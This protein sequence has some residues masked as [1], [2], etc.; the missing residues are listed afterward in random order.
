MRI[1]QKICQF[2]EARVKN[3]GTQHYMFTIFAMLNYVAP[4][5][6]SDL[7]ISLDENLVTLRVTAVLLCF[8]LCFVDYWPIRWRLHYFPLYW[9]CTLL[10]CLPF[11]GTYTALV[12]DEQEYWVFNALLS[13]LL[14]LMLVDWLSFVILATAGIITSYTAYVLCNHSAPIYVPVHDVYLF[15]YFSAFVLIA[16]IIFMRRKEVEQNTKLETMEVFGSAIAHEVKTPIAAITMIASTFK[17]LALIVKHGSKKKINSDKE[18][19][20]KE[21]IITISELDYKMLV[22]TIPNSLERSATEAN[23]VVE[24]LLSA[25]KDRFRN[26]EQEYSIQ[27][28]VN[29]VVQDYGLTKEQ[30]KRLNVSLDDGIKF[31]GSKH[32]MKHVFY[33]LFRNAFKYGGNDVSIDIWSDEMMNTVYFRD[34]GVGI[35]KEDIKKIFQSF[36]TKSTSGS[37]IGLAFC[38]IIMRSIGGA[39]DC[40]S[41]LG[42]YTLFKLRFPG[43]NQNILFDSHKT[44]K[45]S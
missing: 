31:F 45:S 30:K 43:L 25:L 17:S 12:T 18:G 40:E 22:N 10:F 4:L 1:F 5:F 15:A 36:Y 14:L 9:Y 39:I 34:N 20:K 26:K 32:M 28:V 2:A 23:H 16:A 41:K 7:S 27:D 8:G 44:F 6:I 42:E 24:M 29:E 33:N 21:Y 35:A 37:G 13:L 11:L 3:Y 19:R 38:D